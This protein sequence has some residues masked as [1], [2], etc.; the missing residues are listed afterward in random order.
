MIRGW[1]GGP[2]DCDGSRP[3]GN[4]FTLNRAVSASPSTTVVMRTM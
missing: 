1:R 3:W 2:V 4:H